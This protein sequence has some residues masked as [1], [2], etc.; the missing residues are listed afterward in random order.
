MATPTVLHFHLLDQNRRMAAANRAVNRAPYGRIDGTGHVTWRARASSIILWDEVREARAEGSCYLL[1]LQDLVR[2]AE[3]SA[4]FHT[5]R[6]AHPELQGPFQERWELIK[7][8]AHDCEAAALR[9]AVCMHLLHK[10]DRFLSEFPSPLQVTEAEWLKLRAVSDPLHIQVD[11]R[12]EVQQWVIAFLSS[13]THMDEGFMRVLLDW[14]CNKVAV[15]NLLQLRHVRGAPQ[16]LHL[17]LVDHVHDDSVLLLKVLNIKKHGLARV[18]FNHFDRVS[19]KTPVVFLEDLFPL[20]NLQE[21]NLNLPK[22]DRSKGGHRLAEPDERSTSARTQNVLSTVESCI[23][24]D[25]VPET[26]DPRDL[27]DPL[28]ALEHRVEQYDMCWRRIRQASSSL[29]PLDLTHQDELFAQLI[30]DL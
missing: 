12:C 29:G 23:K 30:F 11:D 8:S 9:Q 24:T 28:F 15:M 6:K 16:F 3:S 4:S 13:S 18:G 17:S 27:S 5:R 1:C 25:L 10:V 7:G 2:E 26:A 20:K 14:L 19:E 21:R 22:T